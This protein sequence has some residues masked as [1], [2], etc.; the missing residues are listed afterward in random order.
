M[1]IR[2]RT[3][4]L[5][6]ATV[7]TTA[8]VVG[9]CAASALASPLSGT[10]LTVKVSGG[11]KFTAKAN[12]TVL[13]NRGVNVDCVTRGK[14]HASSA[15]G[16]IPSGTHKGISPVKVGTASNLKFNNC[17]GPLGKVT[18]RIMAEPY[19]VFVDSKTNSKGKTD[20][21][22]SGVKV[23]VSMTG[24]SFNVTGSAPGFYTNGKHTLTMTSNLPVKATTKA[25]LTIHNVS[26]CLGIVHNNDHPRFSSVFTLSR[27]GTIH[28]R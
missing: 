7:A 17:S 8:A 21:F 3:G 22:I 25:Q 14:T 4:S 28:S 24:C 16:D 26:G 15:S 6:L 18:T 9:L 11:G 13:S 12:K 27:K 23:H 5:L 19:K 10:R 2:K 20:G 1:T